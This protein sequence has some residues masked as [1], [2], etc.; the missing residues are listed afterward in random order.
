MIRAASAIGVVVAFALASAGTAAAGKGDVKAPTELTIEAMTNTASDAVLI[1]SV[2][3]SKPQCL[4][5]RKVRVTL[6]PRNGPDFAFDVARTGEG[7]GWFALHDLDEVQAIVPI[8]AYKV[9]VAK[10]K[11]PLSGGRTLI[12]GGERLRR[13]IT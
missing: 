8:D 1:G 13:P 3:S 2:G 9:K 12:C 7:G 6:I 5:N 4:D 10:R 11:I